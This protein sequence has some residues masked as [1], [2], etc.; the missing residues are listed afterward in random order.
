[1]KWIIVSCNYGRLGNRLHTHANILS[2]C[3][4][5][6]YNLLNLSFRL[7]SNLFETQRHHSCES[8]FKTWNLVYSLIKH[9]F[10]GDFIER[11]ILSQKWMKRL[12]FLSHYIEKDSFSILEEQELNLIKTKKLIIINAWDI[13]C[14][15]SIKSVGQF[16]RNHLRPASNYVK[17]ASNA[18]IGLRKH[19]DCLVGIHARRGDYK[20]YLD[21]KYYYSWEKYKTWILELKI[22]LE[23]LGYNKI[24]FVV[25]SDEEPPMSLQKDEAIHYE[26]GKH[27]M[28]DLHILTLCNYN[29]G[30]PS[31]F[32]T[33]ISWN[34]K[35][36]R[37]V[38]YKETKISSIQ[39]FE[40]CA[41][42]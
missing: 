5:N 14:P 29:I 23:N 35:I 18:V 13:R 2:W 12:S 3:I 16:V 1:M 17:V 32:G 31:S 33:W 21:G 39:D 37:L 36:P 4:I 10:I 19:Y 6:N 25:C 26:A 9:K 28:T 34:G 8:Y 11:L 27:F 24:G 22:V 42:C 40:V 7:Y 41:S 38:V 15:T 30:P 20:N